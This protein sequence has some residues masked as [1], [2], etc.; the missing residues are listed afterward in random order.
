[1][2]KKVRPGSKTYSCPPPLVP[3]ETIDGGSEGVDR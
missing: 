3:S 1:M 2:Y